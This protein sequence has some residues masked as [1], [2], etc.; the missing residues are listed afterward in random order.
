MKS[1]N[2]MFKGFILSAALAAAPVLFAATS[3]T[4]VTEVLPSDPAAG[5]TFGGALAIGDDVA[6]VGASS[7][8]NPSPFV[9][10]GSVDGAAYVFVK[11]DGGWVFQQKLV[12]SD[13]T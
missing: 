10:P 3:F 12:A 7:N 1:H 11:T 8:P 5:E 9:S 4:Q 6:V 13:S 2:T